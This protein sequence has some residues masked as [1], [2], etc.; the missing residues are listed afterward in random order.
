[1]ISLFGF[2]LAR[3]REIDEK[4]SLKV[5]V[6][7]EREKS[8][9][10]HCCAERLT[11]LRNL[12]HNLPYHLGFE[13]KE[14]EN[15]AHTVL[16]KARD[17]A[18]I[19]IGEIEETPLHISSKLEGKYVGKCPVV[20]G[21]PLTHDDFERARKGDISTAMYITQVIFSQNRSRYQ[22]DQ[23]WCDDVEGFLWRASISRRGKSVQTTADMSKCYAFS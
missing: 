13:T 23:E 21:R 18:L 17:L 16:S 2:T 4:I 3:D 1:M 22:K 14:E 12:A 6:T 19:S 15:L 10:A 5:S 9:W 8:E 11:P 7:I 20:Y